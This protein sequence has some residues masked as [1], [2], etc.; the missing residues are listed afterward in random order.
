MA[1]AVMRL[2]ATGLDLTAN[3]VTSL[4]SMFVHVYDFII[5]IPLRIE[6]MLTTRN[7]SAERRQERENQPAGV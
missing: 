6:Q 5:V 2:L 7:G 3:F 1:C 4:G